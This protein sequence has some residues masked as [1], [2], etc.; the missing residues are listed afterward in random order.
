MSLQEIKMSAASLWV[1]IATAIAI[2]LAV[3]MSWTMGLILAGLGLV[4]PLAILL[5]WNEPAP[6]KFESIKD[7]RR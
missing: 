6:I 3:D 5:L 4:P 2:A 1:L 7:A